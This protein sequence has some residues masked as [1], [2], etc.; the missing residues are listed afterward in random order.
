[1]QWP[2]IED[3]H[4]EIGK[5]GWIPFGEGSFKNIHTGH[6]IDEN[7]IE[8]DANGNVIEDSSEDI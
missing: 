6:I 2:Y 5:T 1:M 3:D 7:G 4:M 8:Y